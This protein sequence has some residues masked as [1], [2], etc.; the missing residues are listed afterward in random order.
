MSDAEESERIEMSR[1]ERDRLKV[2][3]GV[4]RGERPQKEGARLLRLTT[5]QVR[6]LVRRLEEQGDQGLIHRLRGR[7]S[8]RRLPAEL[9]QQVLTEYQKCYLGFGPTLAAEK[10]AEHHGCSVSRE[11]LRGWMIADGLW[12][13]R[14]HRLPSPHQP[15]RLPVERLPRC[16][17]R[18]VQGEHVFMVPGRSDRVRDH[19]HLAAGQPFS[20]IDDQIAHAPRLLVEIQVMNGP[21]VPVAGIDRLPQ[22]LL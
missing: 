7:P 15:R 20:G 6:R 10:L 14:R 12:Q 21:D 5:R 9:R 18:Q 8:N 17:E 13:D 11:T 2:L 22:Y 4:A 1:R 3:Y 16:A 19:E